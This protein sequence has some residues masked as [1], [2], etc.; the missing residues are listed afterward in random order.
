MTLDEIEF[1]LHPPKER[2][3]LSPE[4]VQA[5]MVKRQAE[6]AEAKAREADWW[7]TRDIWN[8]R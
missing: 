1:V 7:L 6:I 3:T 8:G 5:Y 2:K 4:E